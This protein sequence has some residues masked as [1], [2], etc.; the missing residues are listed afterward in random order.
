MDR[1]ISLTEPLFNNPHHLILYLGPAVAVVGVME[2]LE[3]LVNSQQCNSNREEIS[4]TL[5]MTSSGFELF[6]QALIG[7]QI[8]DSD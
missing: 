2:R 8:Q 5:L 3:D 6:A 4:S 7:I 1:R